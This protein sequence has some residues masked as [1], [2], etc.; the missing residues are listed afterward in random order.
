M[1]W[2][3]L[4]NNPRTIQ[5]EAA[6]RRLYQ[7]HEGGGIWRYTGTPMTG[8]QMLDNNPQTAVI[9]ATPSEL[10]QLH[11]TGRI[12]R[13][14]GTAM[15]GWQILD[16]N[17][18]TVAIAADN[19]ALFQLHRSGK[20]WRYTG[21][22]RTGWQLLDNNPATEQIRAAGGQ[23]FQRHENGRV[24]K[25]TGTP[26]TGW[27]M[28]DDNPS[29][30][31][32][33]ADQRNLFK[34]HRDGT[35]WRYSGDPRTGWIDLGA[36]A[37]GT[38]AICADAGRLYRLSQ[39]PNDLPRVPRSAGA[40]ERLDRLDTANPVWLD[41]SENRASIAI[42]AAGGN[43]YR[44]GKDGLLQHHRL[45][46]PLTSRPPT[47]RMNLWVWHLRP[48]TIFSDLM[49]QDAQRLFATFGLRLDVVN[50]AVLEGH[51]ASVD[52][53]YGIPF[54]LAPDHARLLATRGESPPG[55][56]ALYYAQDVV[57]NLPWNP[58]DVLAGYGTH[59]IGQPGVV[60]D[61]DESSRWTVAHEIGHVMGLAHPLLED[62]NSPIIRLMTGCGTWRL[63]DN[64]PTLDPAEIRAFMDSTLTHP[65]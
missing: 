27:A 46:P 64:V 17:P 57:W 9:V 5:I 40:V 47:R 62:C 34:T 22:P 51:D 24:W 21:T 1:M 2:N 63:G 35:I 11:T 52:V 16:D 50:D 13:F 29:T 61:Q 36:P 12:F 31:S 44:L 43:L 10:Y 3:T 25:Y 32:I 14:T 49:I 65:L 45:D 56:V 39:I 55:D 28:L 41:W 38:A 53:G 8:W 19:G 6:G 20:V 37:L 59:S 4:D 18:Q 48:P 60:V 7:R 26:M 15:T 54:L 33:L 23:L 58:N 42:S 30:N